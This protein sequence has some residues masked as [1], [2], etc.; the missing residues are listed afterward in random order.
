MTSARNISPSETGDLARHAPIATHPLAESMAKDWLAHAILVVKTI[1]LVATIDTNLKVTSILSR[2]PAPENALQFRHIA[3]GDIN[4]LYEAAMSSKVHKIKV[5]T[6]RI[7]GEPSLMT[8]AKYEH[9]NEA[10]MALRPRAVFSLQAPQY[11]AII[12]YL[13]HNWASRSDLLRR[14]DTAANL[15]QVLQTIL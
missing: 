5:F 15:S 14:A 9:E 4:L 11:M 10:K 7:A 12:W 1:A 2:L 8:V 13:K 3:L 6:A